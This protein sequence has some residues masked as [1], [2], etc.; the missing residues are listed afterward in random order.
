MT[1]EEIDSCRVKTCDHFLACG[2]AFAGYL[3][4][5]CGADA[6]EVTRVEI[7]TDAAG[8]STDGGRASSH[9]SQILQIIRQRL[10]KLAPLPDADVE[11]FEDKKEFIDE[12]QESLNEAEG[13]EKALMAIAEMKASEIRKHK[14]GEE[15]AE[16]GG[17]TTTIG[18]GAP[19]SSTAA[20]AGAVAAP[21]M[22]VVKKKKKPA[23]TDDNGVSKRAKSE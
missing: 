18:F 6:E 15:K 12:I 17:V 22:M 13:E 23:P 2:V 1:Q 3:A 7:D 11:E 4:K 9:H 8:A 19:S 16:S 21:T 14:G 20:A 5:M 10:A